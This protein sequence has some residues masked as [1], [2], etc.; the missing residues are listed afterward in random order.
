MGLVEGI[1][2]IAGLIACTLNCK[3]C[4]FPRFQLLLRMP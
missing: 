1:L 3:A 4:N 2:I